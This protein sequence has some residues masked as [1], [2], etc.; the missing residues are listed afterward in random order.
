M[1]HSYL[2]LHLSPLQ[3]MPVTGFLDDR[4][5]SSFCVVLCFLQRKSNGKRR[6]SSRGRQRQNVWNLWPRCLSQSEQTTSHGVM[7]DTGDSP[8][9]LRPPLFHLRSQLPSSPWFRL[10]LRRRRSRPSRSRRQS[11]RRRRHSTAPR[12]SITPPLLQ[13]SRSTCS[14]SR[15]LLTCCAPP[16]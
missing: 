7:T 10:S 14:N 9:S 3:Y 15:P 6:T 12:S 16:R 4:G 8:I 2:T 13:S 11:R 5:I 1:R